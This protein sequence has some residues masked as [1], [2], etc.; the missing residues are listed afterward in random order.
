MS[1][2]NAWYSKYLHELAETIDDGPAL[3]TG[4]DL[5]RIPLNLRK[6]AQRRRDAGQRLDQLADEFEAYL[7]ELVQKPSLALLRLGSAV[8][9]E[10][11]NAA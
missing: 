1:A 10:E 7:T 4:R 2:P 9:S 6:A 3:T 5:W 8:S 11:V